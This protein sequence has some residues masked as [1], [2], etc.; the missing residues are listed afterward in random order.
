[1]Q[2]AQHYSV[3]LKEIQA[4]LD[5]NE[6]VRSWAG[7]YDPNG[8]R[9]YYVHALC[10]FFKWLRVVKGIE[11]S[12]KDLLNE[13]L[14][15]RSRGDIEDRQRHLNMVLEHSRDN[16][17]FKDLGQRRKH[18]I[19]IV[20]KS[21]Y[22]FHD[23]PLTTSKGKF[24]K[25]KKRKYRPKQMSLA[26]AK[27][28][29]G[30]MN[31]RDRAILLCMLQSGMSIGDVIN[32]FGQML[33]YVRSNL[34]AERIKISFDE[35]KG[36]AF[37]YFTFISRDAIHELRKWFAIRDRLVRRHGDCP[38]IFL[39]KNGEPLS[40]NSF[41]GSYLY[42]IRRAKLKD[43][44]FSVTSHMFRKLF[45]TESRAPERGIDQDIVEFMMGHASGIEAVGGPY[46]KTT[47]L[48]EGVIER[49]YAKL[50]PY[51]NI[52]TEPPYG[53]S[54]FAMNK[55]AEDTE[56]LREEMKQLKAQVTELQRTLVKRSYQPLP[57]SLVGRVSPMTD[58]EADE[59]IATEEE[60]AEKLRKHGLYTEAPEKWSRTNHKVFT[61]ISGVHPIRVPCI[62]DSEHKT[63]LESLLH[64]MHAL[65]DQEHPVD[66]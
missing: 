47:E 55:K 49:E 8:T 1:M 15:L 17:D 62:W 53:G 45:K 24:G 4:F 52:Y 7:K 44:P 33:E 51:L 19:F 25:H 64:L 50:E 20:V 3:C 61:R 42:H 40:L 6:C 21:F 2:G 26:A 54:D 57:Q 30:V 14:Q 63:S 48:Y 41:E 11:I 65:Y 16:P 38:A 46:D 28:V 60:M 58:E 43:G 18:H 13:Q 31:Q 59:I 36:N 5:E 23:V 39:A 32:K 22:D 35:R 10:R 66:F 37:P 56:T 34:D 29:L 12:P 27:K 9:K